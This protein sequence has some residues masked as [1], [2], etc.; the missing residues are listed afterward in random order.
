MAQSRQPHRQLPQHTPAPEPLPLGHLRFFGQIDGRCRR[1][2]RDD[3]VARANVELDRPA[4]ARPDGSA[5]ASPRSA[6]PMAPRRPPPGPTAPAR[7]K[8]RRHRPP[9]RSDPGA[10]ARPRRATAPAASS[11]P[12]SPGSDDR[13][14]ASPRRRAENRPDRQ[15][16]ARHPPAP[17]RGASATLCQAAICDA[18]SA[19][20]VTRKGRCQRC[21]IAS[22]GPGVSVAGV[23]ASCRAQSSPRWSSCRAITAIRSDAVARL[24]TSARITDR[25]GRSPDSAGPRSPW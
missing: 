24:I 16:A 8:A 22:S 18:V 6:R 23:T 14:R 19:I 10:S 4:R 5:S 1:N 2:W 3:P 11:A 13:C 12:A 7:Q 15:T 21:H 25:P 9:I 20:S 17:E